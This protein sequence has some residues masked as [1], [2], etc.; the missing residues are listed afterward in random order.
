MIISQCAKKSKNLVDVRPTIPSQF[1]KTRFLLN[2]LLLSTLSETAFPFRGV[3]LIKQFRPYLVL[4][5]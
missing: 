5:P 3:I 2:C 1:N 4:L